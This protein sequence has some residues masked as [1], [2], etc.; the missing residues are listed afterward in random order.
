MPAPEREDNA[1][2]EPRAFRESRK[3]DCRQRPR[4]ELAMKVPFIRRAGSAGLARRME[5]VKSERWC[6]RTKDLR[7]SGRP[8]ARSSGAGL[9]C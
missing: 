4:I 9:V 2:R 8:L 3:E 6:V 1:A 7:I 5:C